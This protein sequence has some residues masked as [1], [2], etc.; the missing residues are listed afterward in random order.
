MKDIVVSHVEKRYGEK[1]VLHDLNLVLPAQRTTAVLAPS[2]FGKTTLMRLILGLEEPDA[3][4]IQ[5]VPACAAVF[6]EDRL[7]G[8]F[9]ALANIRLGA[10]GCPKS[11]ILKALDEFGL[12]GT[13][14]K[15]VS[16]FSGGMRR[17]VS[18]LRALLSSAPALILDEPFHGLDAELRDTVIDLTR[19]RCDG[20]SVILVT[21]DPYEAERMGA[22]VVHLD[23][24]MEA[25][26][27]PVK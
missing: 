21:H 26:T 13:A 20:R 7:C 12:H 24:L 18:L 1:I 3:G 27:Q 6:Q 10:P 4:S 17:R 23:R 5:N 16:S 22:A 2:G 19:Q 8:D 9:G 14:G 25:P 15:P 11:G